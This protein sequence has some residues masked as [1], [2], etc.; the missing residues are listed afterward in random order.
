MDSIENSIS[1][2]DRKFTFSS[3]KET[4]MS[5][6]SEPTSC[7]Y[8]LPVFYCG[9]IFSWAFFS[10]LSLFVFGMK[11]CIINFAKT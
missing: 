5:E 2:Q 9:D 6:C 10:L 4:L 1:V 3:M 11:G 7:G 8:S